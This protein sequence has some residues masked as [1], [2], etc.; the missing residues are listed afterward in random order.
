MQVYTDDDDDIYVDTPDEWD[1]D[2]RVGILIK[3]QDLI[4]EKYDETEDEEANKDA[5]TEEAAN[6]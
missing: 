2:D 1:I 5:R 4:V 3:P 6:E